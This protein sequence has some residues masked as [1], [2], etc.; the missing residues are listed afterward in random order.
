MSDEAEEWKFSVGERVRARE[1]G[2]TGRVTSQ[3][4]SRASVPLYQVEFDTPPPA[5]E[6]E[7][8]AYGAEE[9]E[10]L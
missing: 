9:L 8:F 3:F 2:R 6:E 10:K 7:Q 5:G 4:F 1:N